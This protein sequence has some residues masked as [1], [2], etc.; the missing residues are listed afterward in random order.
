MS[1]TLDPD[2]IYMKLQIFVAKNFVNCSKFVNSHAKNVVIAARFREALPI[3]YLSMWHV[4]EAQFRA[5]KFCHL[6]SIC[7]VLI[8][9]TDELHWR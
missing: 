5:F 3:C 2:T 4:A 9:F 8:K 7:Q 6:Q 1:K